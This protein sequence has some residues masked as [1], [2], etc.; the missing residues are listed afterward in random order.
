MN[1]ILLFLIIAAV[2]FSC[3]GPEQEGDNK[4]FTIDG[5]INQELDAR[6]F[7]Q[8]R[9]EGQWVPVDSAEMVKGRL[10]FSGEVDY[11]VRYYIQIPRTMSL[12]P[13]FLEASDIEM[14]IDVDSIDN[15]EIKGSV[16]NDIYEDFLDEVAYYDND[17][18]KY[19]DA[20]RTARE[21][22]KTD[23][24]AK[25]EATVDSI[26]EKKEQFIL[27]YLLEN[28]DSPVTPYIAYRNLYQL[29][30]KDLE[31]VVGSF[32]EN[33][34]R[35]PYV[36][37]LNNRLTVLRRIAVGQRLV[38]FEM[39]DRYGDMRNLTDFIDGNYLLVDFWASWCGPCRRENPSLVAAYYRYQDKN[40]EI[41]GVS[42]DENRDDWIRAIN[43]DN[44]TWP[45]LSDL[46]GWQSHAAKLYGV[47][48][49]PSNVLID[50]EGYIIARNLR[51]ERLEKKLSEILK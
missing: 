8:Q 32:D 42:L 41:L 11:P 23:L 14:L 12:I 36:D 31:M 28:G 49:I 33:V 45:Q 7:I 9:K 34:K 2:L 5:T 16:S 22:D 13:F 24:A 1:R 30:L 26:Y 46:K 40:F 43:E 19:V 29:N 17:I 15:T 3:A 10:S 21:Q 18:R 38:P 20:M 25:F 51:G 48:S 35:S 44:L 6:V 50:P 47:L 37:F 39:E 4:Q 27:D